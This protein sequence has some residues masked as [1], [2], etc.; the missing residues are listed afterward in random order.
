MTCQDLSS[1]VAMYPVKYSFY[2]ESLFLQSSFSGTC[3]C[4]RPA[5]NYVCEQN[6]RSQLLLGYDSTVMPIQ[7]SGFLDVTIQLDFTT[8]LVYR[9]KTQPYKP[10]CDFI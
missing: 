10:L 6:I 4:E 7:D 5:P 1:L 8:L 3:C 2:S 9:S